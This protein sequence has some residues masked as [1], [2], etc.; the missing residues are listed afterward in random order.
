MTAWVSDEIYQA[1]P[2]LNFNVRYVLR[3]IR[4]VMELMNSNQ[5]EIMS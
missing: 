5:S 3:P 4:L 1:S 2:F